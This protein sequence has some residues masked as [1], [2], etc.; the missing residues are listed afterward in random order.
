[1][2]NHTH[3]LVDHGSETTSTTDITRKSH[4]HASRP[5]RSP[6]PVEGDELLGLLELLV[7]RQRVHGVGGGQEVLRTAVKCALVPTGLHAAD[8]AYISW[9]SVQLRLWI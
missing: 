9:C 1:M 6:V 4:T 8:T 3:A 2:Q 5:Q 7:R